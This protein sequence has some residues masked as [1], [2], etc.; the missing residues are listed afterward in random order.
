[1]M[2]LSASAATPTVTIV[3]PQVL[4]NLESSDFS[5]GQALGGRKSESQTSKL[6]A[7]NGNYKAFADQVGAPLPHDPKTDQLPLKIPQGRG[8][9]PELVRLIREFEDKGQRSPNDRKHGYYIRHLSNNSQYP[10]MVEFDGDEPRHFDYRWLNSDFGYFKLIAVVNRMDR[11]DFNPN[12]CGEVRFIYRLSYSSPKSSSSLPFFLTA[13]YKYPKMENCASFAKRWVGYPVRHRALKDIEFKQLEMNFQSLRFTSGYM[14]DFGGQAMY[15]QR[16]FKIVDG[17]LQPVPLENTPDVLYIEKNPELMA[18][19]VD[20][21]KSGENLKKL[22]EGTLNIDFDP[23]FL[24]KLSVS[25][26]TMGRA[27]T[28]NKPFKRLFA[29]R[30]ELLKQIDLSKLKYI[31]SR[32]GLVERLDNLT[33]MGC[34]QMGG[35]AGF[36]MLGIPSDQFS[37][38]YN[39]QE[40]A[41]SPHAF[42]ESIRR[43]A[44]VARLAESLKPNVFRPH[45]AY[46]RANWTPE[47]IPQAEPL[48]AGRLCFLGKTDFSQVAAC[49][50]GSSCRATVQVKGQ[51][52]MIGECVPAPNRLRAGDICWK[53]VVTEQIELPLDRGPH[54]SFN[55]FSFQDKWENKGSVG[56][57]SAGYKCV[58]PQSGAPLGRTSRPCSLDEENFAKV[59]KEQP[60]ELCANQ[61]GSGFDM[62]AA[63]GDSGACLESKVAR[64]MLDTCSTGRFCREDYICQKFPDYQKI[65][66]RDY[67]R[68]KDGKPVNKSKPKDIKGENI[69]AYRARGIGFCVPTYFLFNMRVDGHPSPVTGLPPGAPVVDR[70]Q[71]VRGYK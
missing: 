59:D 51:P 42:A 70:S 44:Y 17:R 35:T 34:H 47:G 54:P 5:L 64:A 12:S 24:A 19:F 56:K 4:S 18:K 69:Q 40:L 57:A 14:H 8:D 32:D 28:A 15:M 62:C 61:G 22:D 2:V 16:I 66:D 48:D 65:S 9:I 49:G 58:L 13:V 20:W 27:R 25:W 39:R 6:Y 30:R 68:L 38:G 46:P 52:D 7:G 21:L 23:H 55:L 33:C 11:M 41:F 36:H 31:K 43:E 26:S 60:R 63:A 67:A 37:H 45:S 53:G 71:P 10:Y 29:R 1:M 3:D 50:P